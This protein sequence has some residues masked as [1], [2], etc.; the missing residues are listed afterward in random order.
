MTFAHLQDSISKAP[1]ESQ[2]ELANYTN[3]WKQDD[4]FFQA[5]IKPSEGSVTLPWFEHANPAVHRQVFGPHR[6]TFSQPPSGGR[7]SGGMNRPGVHAGRITSAYVT[8]GGVLSLS[9]LA[10]RLSSVSHSSCGVRPQGGAANHNVRSPASATIRA[11]EKE[12]VLIDCSRV[13][14]P[15]W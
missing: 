14:G 10:V 6:F 9:S 5:P 4:A 1:R 11:T 15:S 13:V 3:G 8:K 7:T 2:E 12:A